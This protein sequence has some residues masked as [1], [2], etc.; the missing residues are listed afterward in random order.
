MTLRH[1]RITVIK[2]QF[3]FL[4]YLILYSIKFRDLNLRV[5]Y[6]SQVLK[7]MIFSKLRKSRNLVLAKFSENKVVSIQYILKIYLT[8]TAKSE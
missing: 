1:V 4:Y 3:E 2:Q 5:S 8:N 7:F 6:I